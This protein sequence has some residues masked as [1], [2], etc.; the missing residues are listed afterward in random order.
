MPTHLSGQDIQV[1]GFAQTGLNSSCGK[2]LGL[3]RRKSRHHN[4]GNAL[5]LAEALDK[6]RASPIGQALITDDKVRGKKSA[7]FLRRAHA[8]GGFDFEPLRPQFHF[9]APGQ[10]IFVIHHQ[11]ALGRRWTLGYKHK[12]FHPSRTES[13]D[14]LSRSTEKQL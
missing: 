4:G 13:R 9:D 3:G 14:S 8:I 1:E 10:K 5:G 6:F 12:K 11:N 7:G 2:V